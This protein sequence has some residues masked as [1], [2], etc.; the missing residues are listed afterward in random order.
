MKHLRFSIQIGWR[1]TYKIGYT[2]ELIEIDYMFQ[3]VRFFICV[4]AHYACLTKILSKNN[5]I[6]A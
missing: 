3:L 5:L 1:I 2:G 4:F 6:V